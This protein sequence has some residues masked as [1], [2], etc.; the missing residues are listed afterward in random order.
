MNRHFRPAFAHVHNQAGIGHNQRIGLHGNQGLH[1]GHK[2]FQLAVVRQ[3][4][5]REKEFFAARVRFADAGF[6][7]R[8]FGKFVVARAQRIARAAGIYGIGA[9]IKSGSHALKAAGGQ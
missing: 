6:Q 8:Q 7:H 2:G 3:G 4:V 9:V 1:V 5:Y